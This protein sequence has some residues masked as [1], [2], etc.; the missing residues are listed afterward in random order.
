MDRTH[1]SYPFYRIL[2]AMA[3]IEIMIEGTATRDKLPGRSL[4]VPRGDES[5]DSP[6]P[7]S[8]LIVVSV[9]SPRVAPTPLSPSSSALL[10]Q[11][12]SRLLIRL[13]GIV[14]VLIG[15]SV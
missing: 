10:R 14:E 11:L 12:R 15:C 2:R 5:D 1:Q 13:R 6:L 3:R 9:V 4:E 7:L 8:S